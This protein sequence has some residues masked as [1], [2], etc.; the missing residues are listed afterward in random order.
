M[1]SSIAKILNVITDDEIVL[2]Q[3]VK[4]I[5]AIYGLS[6]VLTL[7]KL[8]HLEASSG[9]VK[10]RFLLQSLKRASWICALFNSYPFLRKVLKSKLLSFNV[11]LLTSTQLEMPPWISTYLAFESVFDYANSFAAVRRFYSQLSSNK[12]N[13]IR[14]AILSLLIPW[15]HHASPSRTKSILF[16]R[17]S[18]LRDFAALFALWNT[19]SLFQFFK[20]SL[21]K[22]QPLEVR[23]NIDADRV[24]NSTALNSRLFK[25]KLKDINE[26]TTSRSMWEKALSCC[27][28][29]NLHVSIKWVAWRQ[30]LW[31]LLDAEH[32]YSS[33]LQIS[34]MLML[35]FYVLDS[36]N[37]Q[38]FVRPG[39]LKYLI[40]ILITDQIRDKPHWQ[41]LAFWIGSN[42]SLRNYH[43]E[44][45]TLST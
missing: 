16:R 17:K 7:R 26:L 27:C 18:P 44:Q 10:A 24:Q 9:Y 20:S 36:E 13:L 37:N 32:K 4:R 35:G 22:K 19:I 25:D 42:L 12:L 39:V 38:M 43:R 31:V 11:A 34:T 2:G 5:L 28:G 8:K 6:G 3:L 1:N 15:L 40:R 45:Q 30:L 23:Q 33:N 41:K 21:Y 14:Q 29:E